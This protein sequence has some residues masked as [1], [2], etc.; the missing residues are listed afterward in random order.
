VGHLGDSLGH[1]SLAGLAEGRDRYLYYNGHGDLATEADA[2]GNQT[3]TSQTYDPFGAPLASQP[4][5]TTEHLFT[6][7]WNKQ[8]DTTSNVV[9]MG[10]RPYDPALGRFLGVDSVDS[11][12]LNNYDYAGQDPINGYDLDGKSQCDSNDSQYWGEGPGG[13]TTWSSPRCGTPNPCQTPSLGGRSYAYA[14]CSADAYCA[15]WK[16]DPV[17]R[18]VVKSNWWERCVNQAP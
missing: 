9:L 7:R 3:G 16:K 2:S 13:Q 15:K 10:A 8:Y 5:N 6:G 4:A 17:C 12:S 1:C 18:K 11:G 14:H